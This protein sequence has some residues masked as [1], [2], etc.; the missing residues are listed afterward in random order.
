MAPECKK[1]T[2]PLEDHTE[3]NQ[4]KNRGSNGFQAGFLRFNDPRRFAC[5]FRGTLE[6]GED[7]FDAATNQEVDSDSRL[8]PKFV[9]FSI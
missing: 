8:M 6:R 2:F 4:D 9:Q 1:K 7:T 5:G 3:K